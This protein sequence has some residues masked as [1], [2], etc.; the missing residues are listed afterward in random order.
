[1]TSFFASQELSEDS[2]F[3]EQFD[4]SLFVMKFMNRLTLLVLTYQTCVAGLGC[5][6]AFCGAYWYSQGVNSSHCDLICNPETFR[7]VRKS[8]L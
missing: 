4:F 3:H 8:I 1:M 5:D 2:S 6:G 7:M